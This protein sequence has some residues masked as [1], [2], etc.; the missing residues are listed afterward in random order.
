M[1]SRHSLVL[2]PPCDEPSA[3]RLWLEGDGDRCF[4]LHRLST[5]KRWR[6]IG[7]AS[8]S[9][10][11]RGAQVLNFQCLVLSRFILARNPF[12]GG[13]LRT[14]WQGECVARCLAVVPNTASPNVRPWW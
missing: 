14:T 4:D 10:Q 6:S 2:F 7:A 9:S 11:I 12:A 1:V 5:Q 13:M 3:Y 8:A